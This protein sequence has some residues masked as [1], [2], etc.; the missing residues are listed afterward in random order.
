[1]TEHKVDLAFR[2]DASSR[3][4]VG[5]VFRSRS[6]AAAGKER[7]LSS[8]FIAAEMPVQLEQLLLAEGH[9]V[10]R[11]A[12]HRGAIS[13]EEPWGVS[14]QRRDA[15]LMIEALE[16]ARPSVV[17][18]DH[19]SLAAPWHESVSPVT[20]ALVCL[21]ELGDRDDACDI[22]VDPSPS[23]PRAK[24][25][26]W[27]RDRIE[28]RGP[29]YAPLHPLFSKVRSRGLR[30]RT[31]VRRI[32]INFGGATNVGL[33]DAVLDLVLN[34]TGD[35]VRVD[36]AAGIADLARGVYSRH[37]ERVVIHD[38]SPRIAE[39]MADA[40]LM[41]GAGG[42][43]L[44]ERCALALPSVTVATA[45]NQ[46]SA[47]AALGRLGATVFAGEI[48]PHSEKN[49]LAL[50]ALGSSLDALCSSSAALERMSKRAAAVTDGAGAGR[51][52]RLA[53]A[54]DRFV[55]PAWVAPMGR[56]SR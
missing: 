25:R 2:V 22:L 3:I 21:D 10:T 45:P 47:S 16:G 8:S 32:L 4:G 7:G 49:E 28:L 48:F 6:I 24:P 20:G 11:I 53:L 56:G 27:L 19:F 40:D 15:S 43:S 38:F 14:Q 12:S 37:P 9:R 34:C 1:M 23:G 26:R 30:R 42:S 5:H 33:I 51:I 54:V 44:W 39:L 50:K 31:E 52:L 41:I 55:A 36:V 46:V 17:V 29:A 35:D 18:V 13:E